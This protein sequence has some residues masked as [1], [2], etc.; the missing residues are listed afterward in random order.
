MKKFKHVFISTLVPLG[1]MGLISLIAYLVC[2][3]GLVTNDCYEQYVP[4]FNAY[5]D[6]LHHKGS[7]FYSLTGSMGYD[8]WAV[9]SYYLVSPLNLIML[10][11]DKADI[12]YVVNILIVV[13][14][15]ICGGTF[16][17]FI[18]NRF[19][20]T[21]CSRVVLFSV[22]YALS[23][24][25]AGFMWNIMWMDGIM[26]FPL[27]IMGLDILMR[28]E[29]HKWYWYTIFLAMLVINSYFIG[30]I[31]CIF[32]LFY[33]F[34][35]D[36]KDFKTFIKKFFTV[37]ASS[38][39]A[40]G[41]SAVILLPSFGGLQ[42]TSISAE[43]L[44]AM[45]FYGSYVE[46]FKNVMV[47]VTPVGID[48]SSGHANLFMTTF[49]LLMGITYF[50]TGSIK[51][52]KKVRIGLLLALM[53]FSLNFK[54]LNY[55]WHGMHEQTGIPN[56]FSY[57]IIFMMITMAFEVCHKR[58]KQVKKSAM[59]VAGVLI[60]AGYAAMAYF[61]NGLIMQAAISAVILIVYF[62]IMAFASGKIKFT[63][64]QVFAYG[65]IVIMLLMGIFTVSARPLGDYGRYINDFEEIN[66]S[67]PA[68]FYREKIDEV[69][70]DEEQKMN[71]DL[72][73][74]EAGMSLDA[75]LEECKFLRNLGH[76]SIVNEA[77]VY[78][79]NSMSLFNTFNNYALTELYCKTG[80]TGGI[81]NVMYFGE[82][83]FMDMLLGVKYYYTRY[84]DVNSSPYTFE[85]KTGDVSI[86][87]NKYA[88]SAGY[89]V[90]ESFAE[91]TYDSG[92]NPFM[93][94]N[95]MSRALGG[96]N[97][98]SLN[99]TRLIDDSLQTDNTRT[100]SITPDDEEM[101][102]YVQSSDIN[103][104]TILVNGEQVYAGNRTMSV[105]DIGHVSKSDK[106]E[107][108]LTY[109]TDHDGDVTSLLYSASVD[110]TK[111][112]AL[113]E[114]LSK[115]MF[116]TTGYNDDGLKGTIELS[117]DSDVMFTIPYAKGESYIQKILPDKLAKAYDNIF[118]AGGWSIKVDGQ[119]TDAGSWNDIFIMLKLD[120]GKHTIEMT[121]VT[122]GFYDGALVSAVSALIF[123]I[124]L[125]ITL[126]RKGKHPEKKEKSGDN[127][128]KTPENEP[129]KRKKND[130]PIA[131]FNL[132]NIQDNNK[133]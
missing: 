43:T 33:F 75:I 36:F 50:T 54:P 29:N 66:A 131:V 56:R 39:L 81:N 68:G 32:I 64:I 46:S 19:P 127:E 51:P 16:S 3:A 97:I 87:S 48:F 7:M 23:G 18:K 118:P 76:L 40:I 13:K 104:I 31:S 96:D 125:V 78:G 85:K 120:A 130:K 71:S 34:T 117:E 105:I 129:P 79:I 90:P 30:Y 72:V 2:G 25:V 107:V 10:F 110:E 55:I 14:T 89:A 126:A 95:S 41:I 119:K 47:A 45:E 60:L 108:V 109:N 133:N 73:E 58:K 57:L 53:L 22:I 83:A 42:S 124:A 11:F 94:M 82:N 67:K 74:Y 28:E 44:P 103:K 15:A 26:L 49:V 17:V 35:Y 12:I 4:F 9:F 84:Y 5:Y 99:S 21:K 37:G 116:V 6:I 113:Y 91:Y 69:Y 122:P 112:A 24:F 128:T 123:I 102:V 77:T 80:A 121:Y 88:L 61:D 111:I 93:T 115:E 70:T 92:N 38:L 114:E 65:E 8:F 1:I 98:Y 63:L 27:V 100:Y 101:L 20:N 52:G 59:A 86:Y 62:I 106:I 132:M